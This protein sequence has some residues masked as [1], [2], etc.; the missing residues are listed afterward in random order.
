[1]RTHPK[2]LDSQRFMLS[3]FHSPDPNAEISIET[4]VS[5]FDRLSI[6]QPGD[7]SFALGPHI[8]SSFEIYN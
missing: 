4:P 6:R 7:A 5:Y 2:I 3:F 8:V 1:M